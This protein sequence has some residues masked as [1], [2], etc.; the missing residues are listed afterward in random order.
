VPE[1]APT[2]P[3]PPAA[4]PA[5]P[6]AF[7][8]PPQAGFAP[9]PQGGYAPQQ[10]GAAQQ[11]VAGGAVDLSD[12]RQIAAA[13]GPGTPGALALLPEATVHGDFGTSSW[14]DTLLHLQIE[15]V[16]GILVIR[17]LREMRWCYLVEGAPV[18]FLGDQPHPGEFLA[19]VLIG[20]GHVTREIWNET[21]RS[22]GLTG[23]MPGEILL[24]SGAIKPQIFRDAMRARAER[25]T[26]NLM[27]MNFGKFTFH[28]YEELKKIFPFD[29]VELL[30]LLLGHSRKAISRLLDEDIYKQTEDFFKQ[31]IR[32]TP[33]REEMVSRLEL[34]EA[35]KHLATVVIPAGWQ[36][37]EMISLKEMEER[38]LLRL[39]LVL[40][41]MGMVEFV[42]QEGS[43][44][45]R[46]RAERF[47]YETLGDVNRR[48]AFEAVRS[49]WSSSVEE[50]EAGYER[51]K[52][53]CRR[54]R[55]E[56]Y[57]DDRIEE[58]LG[59]VHAKLD[60]TWS[61]LKV[62]TTRKEIRNEFVEMGQLRMASELLFSQ[63]EMARYK[64]DNGLARVCYVRVLELD[65]GGPDGAENVAGSKR[66]LAEPELS[67]E[68]V[69]ASGA[70]IKELQRRLDATLR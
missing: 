28:P 57:M 1:S 64:N 18:H 47:L 21:L 19:D 63:A 37:A 54:E 65:P 7:A 60:E 41:A 61:R 8:P 49:H 11:S 9:P 29:R 26:Q 70:D 4:A 20:E 15:Q 39:V 36:L 33:G 53:D 12:A 67:G 45:K 48:N 62:A 16:T 51:M 27:G 44:S 17:A 55:F 34:S 50:V 32:L 59:Q 38:T 10:Q 56:P 35:E 13:A 46:N 68:A 14:R 40:K 43:S 24:G 58:L 69:A 42:Q 5:P 66:A 31:H 2:A 25:I 6:A 23:M 22:Q 30:S 3:A 52:H